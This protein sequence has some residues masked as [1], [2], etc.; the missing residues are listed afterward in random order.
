M[1]VQICGKLV[2]TIKTKKNYKEEQLIKE[3]YS[4]DKVKKRLIDKEV[5]KI[6]NVQDK[7]INIIIN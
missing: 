3:I 7:I 6:I 5:K 4:L 2:T 1:P